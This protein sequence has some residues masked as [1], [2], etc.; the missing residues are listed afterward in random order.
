M[1]FLD[2]LFN[3]ILNREIPGTKNITLKTKSDMGVRF[4]ND[5]AW[6]PDV[7][8]RWQRQ[9]YTIM[10][11]LDKDHIT[12]IN[13]AVEQAVVNGWRIAKLADRI[14]EIDTTMEKSQAGLIARYQIGKLNSMASQARMQ[15]AGLNMYIWETAHDERVCGPCSVMEG[16]LCRLDDPTVYSAD[17]GKTWKPRPKTAVMTHP[18]ENQCKKE[19]SCRCV[20]GPYWEELMGEVELSP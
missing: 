4:P 10:S 11:N 5:E 2:R 12:Q 20:M 14:C 13:M 18:G 16:K 17:K 15:H 3:K 7:K 9:N 1:S 6:W 8:E 19:G